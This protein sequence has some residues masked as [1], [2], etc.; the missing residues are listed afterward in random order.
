LRDEAFPV[1]ADL[2]RVFFRVRAAFGQRKFV[3]MKAAFS[4]VTE[5]GF[6]LGVRKDVL[7]L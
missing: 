3:P 1:D 7:S 4:D 6:L 5:F 2:A